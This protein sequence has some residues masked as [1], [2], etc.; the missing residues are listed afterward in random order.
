M[1]KEI[2]TS[3]AKARA[4]ITSAIVSLGSLTASL[5]PTDVR[6]WWPIIED[7]VSS[8]AVSRLRADTMAALLRQH[9]FQY[10]SMDA[11]M[12]CCM[13]ILGQES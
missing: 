6:H 3:V 12:K 7:V 5:L 10:I 11:T 4:R 9:E 2:E 8:P 1:W 13:S